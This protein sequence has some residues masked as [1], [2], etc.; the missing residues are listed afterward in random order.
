MLWRISVAKITAIDWVTVH[1]LLQASKV[2]PLTAK[3]FNWQSVFFYFLRTP[4]AWAC[5]L[6]FGIVV[7]PICQPCLTIFQ[8]NVSYL[9]LY[10]Y[11]T[12][13]GIFR[14]ILLFNITPQCTLRSRVKDS[15]THNSTVILSS[16]FLGRLIRYCKLC[17]YNFMQKYCL[18]YELCWVFLNWT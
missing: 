11:S 17:F 18:V 8:W 1:V 16:K 5:G 3:Y 15:I 10:A 6:W 12:S 7:F 4:L 13:T 14:L 9:L 2:D